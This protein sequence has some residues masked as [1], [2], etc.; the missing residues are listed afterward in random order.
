M[1]RQAQTA[2]QIKRYLERR[3][4]APDVADRVVRRLKEQGFVNDAAFA[5][6]WLERRVETGR[7]SIRQAVWELKR[8]GIAPDVI[9]EV[10]AERPDDEE[11]K[12]AARLVRAHRQ[13]YHNLP[14]RDW[15]L[16]AYRTLLRKGFR[17]ETASRIVLAW[18]DDGGTGG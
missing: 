3:G 15:R 9:R 13:R 6:R 17:P 7:T 5:R 12:A 4:F 2:S 14:L 1:A 18:D 11:E 10:L 8:R 16:K